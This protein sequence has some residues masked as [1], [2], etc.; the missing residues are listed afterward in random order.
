MAI[1]ASVIE[2][3]ER[4]VTTEEARTLLLPHKGAEG[5]SRLYFD[6]I[7]AHFAAD[8]SRAYALADHWKTVA[9]LGDDPAY[10]YRAKGVS[11]RAKSDWMASA[12]A[13]QKAGALAKDLADKLTFRTGAVDALARAQKMAEA[14]RLGAEL[15]SGLKRLGRRDLAARVLLSLGNTLILQDR[16]VEARRHLERALPELEEAS[17]ESEIVSALLGLSTTHLYS[18]NPRTAAEFAWRTQER[19]KASGLDFAVSIAEMNLAH[20]LLLTGRPD[21]ALD[22]FLAVRDSLAVAPTEQ[23]RC[24]EFIGDAYYR[25]NLWPEALAAYQEALFRAEHTEPNHE[26]NVRLGIGHCLLA[27]GQPE[28]A[29]PYFVE[30]KRRYMRLNNLAW[31]SAADLGRSQSLTAIGKN[32]AAKIALHE[33]KDLAKR[34]NSAFHWCEAVLAAQPTEPDLRK[35]ARLIRR[36]NYLGLTWRAHL[37]RAQLSGKGA[38]THY[39]RMADSMLEGRLLTTSLISRAHFLKDKSDALRQYLREL[40]DHPTK[41]NVAEALRV[42]VETRSAALI[43]EILA[44]EHDRLGPELLEQLAS[45][46]AEVASLTAGE[47]IPSGSRGFASMTEVPPQAQRR[48]VEVARNARAA[49]GRIPFRSPERVAVLTQTGDRLYAIARDRCTCLPISAPDLNRSLRWLDYEL[50]APMVDPDVCAEPALRALDDLRDK[51]VKPWASTEVNGIS[52]DGML[53]RVPW[54]CICGPHVPP[55][56]VLHPSSAL[57]NDKGYSGNRALLW[58]SEAEDLHHGSVE[59]EAFLSRHPGAE[60][61]TSAKAAIESLKRSYDLVHVVAHSRHREENP[62]FSSIEFADGPVFAADIARSGLRAKLVTLAACDTGIV[63]LIS[64]EEPDGLARAF[65]ARGVSHVVA[66]GWALHDEAAARAFGI[67]YDCLGEGKSIRATL[68]EARCRVRSWRAHPY[69]WGALTLYRGY[70]L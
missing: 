54:Q 6:R 2:A 67:F 34:S 16:M 64:R 5:L 55:D 7:A 26:A 4:A 33:A 42:I 45:V 3:L 21:A 35:A 62:M 41:R 50:M 38:R 24:I 59:A 51:L 57:A 13:F 49:I 30:A 27:V 15:A 11:D 46:R 28:E 32:R 12:K 18:G 40:L 9:E 47:F 25:L 48:W 8:P 39:R 65:L 31:A 66:S 17:L 36:Y 43:D 22:R 1:Q 29:I 69:Y 23:T 68:N 19:A 61:C 70:G 60:V 52:P 20:T 14:E 63:S 53:W 58:V 56:L 44:A 37:R 10:A